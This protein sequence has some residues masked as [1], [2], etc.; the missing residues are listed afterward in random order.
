MDRRHQVFV[1]STFQDLSEERQEVMQALLELDCIPSGMELF[2]AA[3]EDQWT[4]IKNV[5]DDCDYYVVIVAGRYG[6]TNSDGVSFT[7]A[8]YR[9]AVGAGKPVIG[10]LHKTPESIRADRCESAPEGKERL[11]AFRQLVGQKMVRY[12]ETPAELGSVVSRS[13][14]KLQRTHPSPGWVRADE[15]P[16]ESASTQIL[17]LKTKVEEL[18]ALLAASSSSA[19]PGTEILSQSDDEFRVSFSFEALEEGALRFEAQ[20]FSSTVVLTWNQIFRAVAPL[21]IDE[22]TESVLMDQLGTLIAEETMPMWREHEDLRGH[23]LGSFEIDGDS[24]QQIKVQLRALG[25]IAK[26]SKNRSVKDKNTYW[27]LTPYGDVTMTRLLAI[28][29]GSHEPREARPTP[30]E[31]DDDEGG[32]P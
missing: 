20:G 27:T 1:S 4:L 2:P 30:A 21:M 19:P 13:V 16:D 32:E 24:F 26:S 17:R 5:I 9:Y 31:A 15:V 22:A 28:K 3:N 7:E 18:E 14:I 25:L 10:F 11:D 29:K 6:S 12:W 8:E 23:R